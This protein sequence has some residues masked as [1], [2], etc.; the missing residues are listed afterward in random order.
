MKALI[1]IAE[2]EL[3]EK[4]HTILSKANLALK[5]STHGFG[6]ADSKIQNYLGLGD[7]KKVV[8]IGLTSGNNVKLIY[9]MLDHQ[10]EISKA[11]RGIA[12][13]I[14]VS[15]AN[16]A[17][18]KACGI[19][20]EIVKSNANTKGVNNTMDNYQHELV[21]TI[22]QRGSFEVV[23]EAAKKAGA[24]GGTLMHCLGIGG[25]EAAKFLG[26]S[27][28]PEKDL[29]MIVVNKEDKEI[30]MKNILDASGMLTDCRGICFSLP[31]DSAFGLASKLEFD[32]RH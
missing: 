1:V 4:I 6:T 10:M 28:Q 11:G 23:K 2:Y 25:E 8:F 18:V 21:I 17:A 16:S 3:H 12:F 5:I 22:V 9:N 7:N 27:I 15:G 29:I 26:I 24:R 14:P 19:N 32:E 30:V 20:T 31:V 13:T